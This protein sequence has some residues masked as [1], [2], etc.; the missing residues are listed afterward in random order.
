MIRY[1]T[2]ITPESR[3]IPKYKWAIMGMLDSIAG[4]MQTLAQFKI[5]NSSGGG[6][7]VTLLLQSAIPSSMTITKIFLGT[8]YVAAQYIGAAIV[9]SGI[10]VALIPSL[11]GLD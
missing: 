3:S 5:A 11:S 8:K 10:V 9:M 6:G 1:G 7:L 4:I 2:V